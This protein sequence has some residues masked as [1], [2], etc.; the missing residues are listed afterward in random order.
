MIIVEAQNG[1]FIW[2]YYSTHAASRTTDRALTDR[3]LGNDTKIFGGASEAD[4]SRRQKL[5]AFWQVIAEE[6]RRRRGT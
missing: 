5:A 2:T 4:V 1:P 3:A 6:R